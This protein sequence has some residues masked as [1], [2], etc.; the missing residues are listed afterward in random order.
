LRNES[1]D[2]TLE[3]AEE[4]GGSFH[5]KGMK[6]EGELIPILNASTQFIYQKPHSKNINLE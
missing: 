6:K 3:Q 4:T 1:N 5:C 2:E